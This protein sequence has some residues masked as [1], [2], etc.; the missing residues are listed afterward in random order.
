MLTNKEKPNLLQKVV[1]LKCE[2]C[3]KQFVKGDKVVQWGTT[4][5]KKHGIIVMDSCNYWAHLECLIPLFQSIKRSKLRLLIY[6]R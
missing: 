1:I 4:L 6:S 3:G 5:A 2:E